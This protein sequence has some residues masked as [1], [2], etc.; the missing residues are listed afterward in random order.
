MLT[1]IV[2]GVDP[3][4]THTK[5][6]DETGIVV[7]GKDEENIAYVLADMSIKGA[8]IDWAKQAL[9]AY[10][11]YNANAIVVETNQGGD[12]VETMLR[13]LRRDVVIKAVRATKSKQCRAAPIAMLYEQGKVFHARVFA[14]L[15]SQM[16]RYV[17]SSKKSPDRLDALVWA[18]T[19]LMPPSRQ[20]SFGRA[21]SFTVD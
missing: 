3:A 19:Y 15:E 11:M 7:V 6:S 5:H 9:K 8:P 14:E 13:T 4:V 12:L 16:C 21:W 2:V 17:T 10:E 1:Q 18:L 20:K